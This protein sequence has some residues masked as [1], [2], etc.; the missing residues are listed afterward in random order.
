[1]TSPVQ[2]EFTTPG[3]EQ[4]QRAVN[5]L[6]SSIRKLNNSEA[7]RKAKKSKDRWEREDFIKKKFALRE[8][9]LAEKEILRS[10][11]QSFSENRQMLRAET[12]LINKRR[13]AYLGTGLSIMFAGQAIRRFSEGALRSLLNTYTEVM[14]KNSTFGIMTNRLAASWEFLKFSIMDALQQSGLLETVIGWAQSLTN[15]FIA[16]PDSVKN[17]GAAVLG[18]SWVAGTIMSPI[19]QIVTAMSA[20]WAQ[21]VANVKSMGPALSKM[22]GVVMIG[23]ALTK[24]DDS[25]A[26]FESGEFGKGFLAALGTAAQLAGGWLM[27]KGKVG[28]GLGVFAI[29]ISLELLSEAQFFRKMFGWS[30]IVLGI[31]GATMGRVLV[32]IENFWIRA[33]AAAMGKKVNESDLEKYPNFDKTV[34]KIASQQYQALTDMDKW[35]ERMLASPAGPAALSP[36]NYSP[37]PNFSS[38]YGGQGAA[39]T[40]NIYITNA[41]VNDGSSASMLGPGQSALMSAVSAPYSG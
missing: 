7:L 26:Y 40:S 23:Y 16:L 41:Y 31:I 22:A 36:A 17:F 10:A 32:M 14:G 4:A 38:I 28:P 25:F 35:V 3:I 20:D 1:M 33:K 15:A 34:N 12:N 27:F 9:L 8:E 11:K 24:V 5:D 2:I 37:A 13:M 6:E 29:G 19:G 21:L 18:L 39:S 30:A